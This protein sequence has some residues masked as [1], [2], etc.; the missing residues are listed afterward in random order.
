M[1]PTSTTAIDA[2]VW[3]RDAW[4]VWLAALLFFTWGSA[5]TPLFDLDEGAFS[6]ATL[7][8]LRNHDWLRTWLNGQPR[9]DKP[10]LT[11]WIQAGFV[12]SF[13][14]HELCFRAPSIL[15][16][17]AWVLAVFQF[18]REQFQRR[19][20]AWLAAGTLGLS[21]MIGVIGHAATADGLL[22]LW[23]ALAFMDIWRHAQAP[24]TALI[25]RIYLWMGLGFLTKG[26]VAIGLPVVTSLLFYLSQGRFRDWLGAA[27]DWRGWLV[28]LGVIS[29]WLVPLA[30]SGELDFLW[31]FLTEHNVGRYTDAA[32]GHSGGLWFYFLWLPLVL[33]PF[34]GLLPAAFAQMRGWKHE[35]LACYLL[36]WFALVFVIVSFAATKLPHYMLY[37]CTPFFLLFGRAWE[38]LP[39][40]WVLLGPA[41][42]L[43]GALAS[44]PL[45]LPYALP[46]ERRAYEH[47]VMQ[48]ALDSIG[49]V[50]GVSAAVSLGLLVVLAWKRLPRWQTVLG[51]GL[52]QALLVWAGVIPVLAAAQQAP[53]REAAW[54][55]RD[56]GA[57]AVSYRTA[58]P[59]FSVYRGDITESRLPEA[60]E[61]VF[62][63]RDRL[64]SLREA[65]PEVRFTTVYERGGIALL[66]REEQAAP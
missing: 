33:L 30:V 41:A 46:P 28:L 24:R 36:I 60:G 25:L 8:M 3:R 52:A 38:R 40:P 56:S 43:C 13:G 27:F 55:A 1:N 23:L 50:Y 31:Q 10:L 61:L 53:V 63:R 11:Y 16:A 6:Q 44:L 34:T 20:A 51:A 57:N 47:G 49:P 21:L 19:E 62:L 39:G 64:K 7:E 5:W 4:L 12:A 35:P 42:L 32:E 15:A 48:L 14:V 66:R 22:N 26:P 59:S 37:G 45:W 65:L 58:L 9:Y 17:S 29:I 2:A 18:A 54:I